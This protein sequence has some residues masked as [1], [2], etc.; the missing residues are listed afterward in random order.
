M[1]LQRR[2]FLSSS[3]RRRNERRSGVKSSIHSASERARATTRRGVWKCGLRERGYDPSFLQYTLHVNGASVVM[4][5]T[6][7]FLLGIGAVALLLIAFWSLH[8]QV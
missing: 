3:S 2:G 7:L 4:L 6:V 1:L 8:K 5:E